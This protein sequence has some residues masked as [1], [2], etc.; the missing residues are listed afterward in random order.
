MKTIKCPVCQKRYLKEAL[1]KHISQMAVR[2]VYTK[3][4]KEG[5]VARGHKLPHY[6]FRKKNLKLYK[7]FVII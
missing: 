1:T 2:E 3:F 6:D 5:Y 7:K 4:D